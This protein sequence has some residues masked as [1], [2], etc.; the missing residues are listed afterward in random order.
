MT[1]RAPAR[2][3]RL[4][5]RARLTLTYAGL[6]TASGAVLITLVYLYMRFVPNY[7]FVDPD[8]AAV[9]GA[10]EYGPTA[11]ADIA[12]TSAED[13][14]A[15]LLTASG[16]ALAIL[17]VLSGVAGWVVAG[18]IIEPIREIGVA[19]R[20]ASTGS[21]DHRIA[22][23]GPRD[24]I[25]DLADT[26]DQM[27]A[28]LDRSFNAHRRFTAGA[29]HELRTPLTTT[30]TM[31]DVSLADPGAD[32]AELRALAERVR[33]VN[34]SSIETVDALLDLAEADASS[35]GADPF[36]LA[37]IARVAAREALPEAEARRITVEG[38]EGS[39]TAAGSPVLMRQAVANLVRNAVRHNRSGGHV[40]IRVDAGGETARLVVANTGAVV[41]Q[42]D[43]ERLQEP[44]A[45]GTG[46][47]LTRGNGHGIGLAV[48]AAVVTAHGGTL[49][50]T[51]NPA[52][53]VTAEMALPRTR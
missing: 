15:N 33:E 5:I 36:D 17:A 3:R 10:A 43:L 1:E 7:H 12:V 16:I 40:E 14:L 30:K 20:L 45:R 47:S 34:Q 31:I 21:L 38:P 46:R 13:F 44:F 35:I 2:A 25:R 19:A 52:G 23:E 41:D 39:A 32:A 8:E 4:T 24:E 18:R 6:V 50:L 49:T 37:E 11:R 27:L 28:S 48:V 29:S 9:E 53:G 26:M 22:L 42:S 51:A